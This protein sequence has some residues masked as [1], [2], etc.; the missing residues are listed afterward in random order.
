MIIEL[1][2]FCRGVSITRGKYWEMHLMYP[3]I[4]FKSPGT[5][6]LHLVKSKLRC[7]TLW[8]HAKYIYINT[9]CP[10]CTGNNIFAVQQP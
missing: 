10:V 6:I 1:V 3:E 2:S 7:I 4:H 9:V 5:G 8:E